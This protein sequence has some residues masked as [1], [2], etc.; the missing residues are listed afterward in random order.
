M[1]H[2]YHRR[3]VDLGLQKIDWFRLVDLPTWKRN[4][5]VPGKF[6]LISPFV[7]CVLTEVVVILV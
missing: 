3:L 6:Y 4:K 1:L 5:I 2:G 7:G